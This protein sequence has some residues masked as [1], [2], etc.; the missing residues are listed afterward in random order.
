MKQIL[1]IKAKA[2]KKGFNKNELT[3]LE[4]ADMK[5]PS[6]DTQKNWKA[7]L[8]T[9]AVHALL[10]LLFFLVAFKTPPPP[11]PTPDEGIEV[12][13]G[14]S[15]IGYGDDQPMIPGDPAP[16]LTDAEASPLPSVAEE[17]ATETEKE[18]TNREEE[19]LPEIKKPEV[20]NTKPKEKAVEQKE[21]V[22]KVTEAESKLIPNLKNPTVVANTPTNTENKPV[23][24]KPKAVFTGGNGTGGNQQDSYNNS[25]G[26]GK[27]GGMGD[28]GK[29][30]GTPDADSYTGNGGKGN[31]PGGMPRVVTGNRKITKPYSFE[32]DLDKATIF[33]IIKVS[34]AGK[35]SFV[36]FGKNSTSR[37]PEY[38][39]AIIQYLANIEFDITDKEDLVT[40]QF[41]FNIK[42]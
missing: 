33:A 4:Q 17:A 16:E 6:F 11:P 14:D 22:K 38:K 41:I 36:D 30:N 13:L 10:L 15:E 1:L 3:S 12:N 34:P 24:P 29:K 21:V 19:D 42:D 37:K 8:I 9:L 25:P 18:T 20:K 39:K 32:G 26:E 40:V 23:A 35:G 27:A 28:Q 31:Q 5:R 2:L 7:A